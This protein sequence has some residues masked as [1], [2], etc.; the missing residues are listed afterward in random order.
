MRAIKWAAAAG[1]ILLVALITNYAFA[2]PDPAGQNATGAASQASDQS[3]VPT[4]E[5][6]ANMDFF[7][8][9]MDRMTEMLKLTPEQQTKIKPILEQESGELSV[10]RGNP[11][12]SDREK[13]QRLKKSVLK[14]DDKMKPI[15]TADQ[16]Q[17]LESVRAKQKEDV[18][19]WEKK[20][21][22]KAQSQ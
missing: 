22:K 6:I 16:W 21:P 10:L 3:V 11:S 19:E 13:L 18:K 9:R 2:S 7:S 14:A 5:N 17:T 15:L 20:L 1:C 12:I 4:L 8:T